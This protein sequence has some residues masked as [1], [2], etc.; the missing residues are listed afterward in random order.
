[1]VKVYLSEIDTFNI[2]VYDAETTINYF[3]QDMLDDYGVDIDDALL[4]R[5]NK[6]KEE[7]NAIQKE[8]YSIY[9]KK[10]GR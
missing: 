2:K 3:G 10:R 6:M 5:Y 1:M 4:D 9:D 8:L 7:Y